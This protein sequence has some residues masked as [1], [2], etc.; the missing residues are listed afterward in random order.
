MYI[1]NLATGRIA[2]GIMTGSGDVEVQTAN[3]NSVKERLKQVLAVASVAGAT[4]GA[5]LMYEATA[6]I[7]S[8]GGAIS[9]GT[10]LGAGTAGAALAAVPVVVVGGLGVLLSKALWSMWDSWQQSGRLF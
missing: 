6:L 3:T 4:G 9:L 8:E 1:K 2:Q 7:A 10:V 5:L